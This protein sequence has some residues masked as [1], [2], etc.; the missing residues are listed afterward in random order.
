MNN[1]PAWS[2]VVNTEGGFLL[3]PPTAEINSKINTL[4]KS[5][6]TVNLRQ[7][8]PPQ[9]F[10]DQWMPRGNKPVWRGCWWSPRCLCLFLFL[11]RQRC[12]CRSLLCSAW[13]GC[14]PKQH[15]ISRHLTLP[16]LPPPHLLQRANCALG[17]HFYCPHHPFPL[18]WCRACEK[19]KKWSLKRRLM[20]LAEVRSLSSTMYKSAV[21][22]ADGV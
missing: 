15:R 16:L 13:C 19:Q 1:E 9:P 12:W 17:C 14:D 10:P 4:P 7:I 5:L 22:I 8:L 2:L 3:T 21:H 20:R 18:T 11:S 6:R